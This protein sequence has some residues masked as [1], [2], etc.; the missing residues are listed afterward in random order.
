M[1]RLEAFGR[2][3]HEIFPGTFAA[4]RVGRVSMSCRLGW[5][6]LGVMSLSFAV[7]GMRRSAGR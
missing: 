6:S 3:V 2:E 4:M 1:R 5:T 7:M